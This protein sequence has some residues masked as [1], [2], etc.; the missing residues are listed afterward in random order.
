MVNTACKVI[1][2]QRDALPF[3]ITRLYDNLTLK[4]KH[5]NLQYKKHKHIEIEIKFS[6][7]FLAF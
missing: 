6:K 3:V 4:R 2:M 7:I 5:T 1:H